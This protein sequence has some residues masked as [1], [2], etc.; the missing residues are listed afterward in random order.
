MCFARLLSR[1]NAVLGWETDTG[2]L[3]AVKTEYGNGFNIYG[4]RLSSFG[5]YTKL[6]SSS[7]RSRVKGQ[8]FSRCKIFLLPVSC[9]HHEMLIYMRFMRDFHWLAGVY[10]LRIILC[11]PTK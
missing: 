1:G 9:L 8:G 2:D 4:P 6:S 11:G 5:K 7:S 10:V 3:L